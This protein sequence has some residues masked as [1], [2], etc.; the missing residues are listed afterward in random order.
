MPLLGAMLLS[1]L[2]GIVLSA[3]ALFAGWKSYR[4]LDVPREPARLIE[5]LAC[6][7]LLVLAWI[8]M[9]LLLLAALF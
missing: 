9:A 7:S 1:V 3:M 4:Q 2:A 8:S 5:V 6:G